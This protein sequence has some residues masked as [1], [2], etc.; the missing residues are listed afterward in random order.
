MS[1][2]AF[3]VLAL[4]CTF[5]SVLLLGLALDFSLGERKRTLRLLEAQVGSTS[6]SAIPNLR[7]QE[8]SR[9][10][11]QRAILPLVEM[12]GRG[13]RR[14][15]PIGA[16]ER[17]AKKLVLAGSPAGWDA[18]RIAAFKMIG[19]IAGLAF[20]ILA[21]SL[22]GLPRF[23][24]IGIVVLLAGVGFFAPDAVLDR[25]VQARQ[26]EILRALSDTLDLLTISVEAGLSL[27]A[28]IGQVVKTVPGTLSRELARMLQEIQLGVSRADAFKNLAARTDV[29]ELNGFVLAMVQADVFGVPIAQVLRA[30]SR[31]LRI[32]RRQKAQKQAQQMP[33]KI[34][35]PLILCILPALFIVVAGPGVIRILQAV[36]GNLG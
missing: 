6:A 11:V 30:Q 19:G 2:T 9:G 1:S 3:L 12:A 34:V 26:K 7:E 35:F 36:L 28:A 33:V 10:F 32:R 27:N 16:R 23:T 22:L 5:G 15:T 21:T 17:Y 29:E 31:D 8:L 4:L 25:K 20:G 24:Q 18:E 14:F 13:A